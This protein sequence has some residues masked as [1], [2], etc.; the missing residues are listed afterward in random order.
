[1]PSSLAPIR[2]HPP[3][4]NMLNLGLAKVTAV[5]GVTRPSKAPPPP[6]NPFQ[7]SFWAVR[8][9][10]LAGVLILH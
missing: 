1:M 9:K 8:E 3:Q 2:Q 5:W 4:S 10:L 6:S 7:Q